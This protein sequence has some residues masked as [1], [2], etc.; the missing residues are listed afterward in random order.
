MDEVK[1]QLSKKTRLNPVNIA[2][3]LM[4][5]LPPKKEILTPWLREKDLAMIYASRGLGKTWFALNVGYAIS[6]GSDCCSLSH[7]YRV[8]Y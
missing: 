1:K 7:C 8:S 2:D 4:L 3:L 5:T 6:S